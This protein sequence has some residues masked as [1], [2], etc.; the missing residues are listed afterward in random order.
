LATLI[1]VAVVIIMAVLRKHVKAD[2]VFKASISHLSR[3][4]RQ[5][6]TKNRNGFMILSLTGIAQP[7]A[8]RMGVI[9]QIQERGESPEVELESRNSGCQNGCQ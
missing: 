8:G 6:L 9:D 4:L 5:D 3:G 2:L 1:I 7:E